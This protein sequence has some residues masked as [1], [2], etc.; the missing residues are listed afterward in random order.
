M[1]YS[2][3]DLLNGRHHLEHLHFHEKIHGTAVKKRKQIYE[4]PI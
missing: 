1:L 2:K 3:S 4:L